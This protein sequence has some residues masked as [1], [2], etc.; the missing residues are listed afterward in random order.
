MKV[1]IS[2][3]VNKMFGVDSVKVLGDRQTDSTAQPEQLFMSCA[4]RGV[5]LMQQQV[6]LLLVSTHCE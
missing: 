2:K 3:L 5:R 6:A 1:S 4:E